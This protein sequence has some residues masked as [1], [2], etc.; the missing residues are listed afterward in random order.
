MNLKAQAVE[1][2]LKQLLI[3]N[4]L[5]AA[6]KIIVGVMTGTIAIIADGFHSATDASGNIVGLIGQRMASRPPDEDHPYGH[7]RFETLATL[8]I[9]GLLLLGAWEILQIAIERLLEGSAPEIGP[10]QFGILIS[11]LV[12]NIGVATYERRQAKRL[13]SQLLLADA[14]HTTTDIWVTISAMLSLVLVEAGLGW[15]DAVIALLIVGFIG[16]VGWRIIRDTSM[17]L[18]DSAPLTAKELKAAVEDTPGV[19]KVLRARSRGREDNIQVDL[20]VQVPGVISAELA[21][22]LAST[23]QQRI[24]EAFPQ[25]DEVRVQLSADNSE[26]L[27]YVTAARAAAD[28]MGL[29]VHEVIGVSTPDG[30]VLELHVEVPGGATLEDAHHQIDAFEARLHEELELVD[31]VTHI[32]PQATPTATPNET[33]QMEIFRQQALDQ[34]N[35]FFPQGN[36]HAATVRRD[37]RGFVLTTHCHLPGDMSIESAHAIAED[38]ELHLRTNFPQF[39]RVTI[40]TEPEVQ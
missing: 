10:L 14:Q 8:A 32:E 31:I 4:A 27:D 34:L 5:V 37:G 20:D 22:N 19:Q 15:M 7:E 3:L 9:G 23:L 40:H 39:H 21:Q 26:K 18:V 38:A 28:A 13:E 6:G 33:P 12:I 1:Q 11:T 30:R 2:V 17:V 24:C 35:Q 16:R 25:I 29:G 36:W